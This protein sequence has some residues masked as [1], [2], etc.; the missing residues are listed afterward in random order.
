MRAVQRFGDR[1]LPPDRVDLAPFFLVGQ[2]EACF[3]YASQ[4]TFWEA[5]SGSGQSRWWCGQS[6][7]NRSPPSAQAIRWKRSTETGNFGPFHAQNRDACSAG[8][9][10]A[11]RFL[12]VLSSLAERDALSCSARNRE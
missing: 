6:G 2:G 1:D 4:L 12:R 8:D 11:R 5:V 3:P 10:P 7:A 9:A